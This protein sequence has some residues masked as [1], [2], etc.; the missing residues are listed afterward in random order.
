MRLEVKD[1]AASIVPH[2]SSR[3]PT[4]GLLKETRQEI[5][6]HQPFFVR[7]VP[8]DSSSSTRL[9]PR[10]LISIPLEYQATCSHCTQRSRGRLLASVGLLV[11]FIAPVAH[12]R[13]V[14]SHPRAFAEVEQHGI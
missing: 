7:V 11:D 13:Y 9:P 8:P 2:A 3:L 14:R 5:G 12:E 1:T 6:V 10:P 4:P